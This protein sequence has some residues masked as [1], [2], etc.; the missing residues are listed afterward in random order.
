M[1]RAADSRRHHRRAV[2]VVGVCARCVPRSAP[3]RACTRPR[4]PDAGVPAAPC[5]ESP[6][7]PADHQTQRWVGAR[8]EPRVSSRD[9]SLCRACPQSPLPLVAGEVRPA[10]T[11]SCEGVVEVGVPAVGAP[12]IRRHHDAAITGEG[13]RQRHGLLLDGDGNGALEFKLRSFSQA[14]GAVAGA[15]GDVRAVGGPAD[16][17]SVASVPAAQCVTRPLVT[18]IETT[19]PLFPVTVCR[20]E[21]TAQRRH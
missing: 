13:R 17:D 4:G 20:P 7:D 21:R 11:R 8:T 1:L 15:R 3:A 19:S 2:S 9:R 16:P 10:P 5:T 12:V 18:S 14:R 6:R